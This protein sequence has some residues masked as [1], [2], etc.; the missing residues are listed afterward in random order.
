[1]THESGERGEKRDW[2]RILVPLAAYAGLAVLVWKLGLFKP[3]NI[4]KHSHGSILGISWLAIAVVATYAFLGMLALPV[5]PLA[6]GAGALFGFVRGAIYV[7]VGSM[8]GAVG[9]FFLARTILQSA[10]RRLLG[11]YRHKF[12]GLKKGN[13]S[14][15]SFRIRVVPFLPFG[16]VNYAAAIAKV[17]A[18][19]FLAG[20]ALGILPGTLLAA[21]IGDRFYAGVTGGSRK[22]L[23]L[24]I[25]LGLLLLLLSFVPALLKK[26]NNKI[27]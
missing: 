6:Y 25:A 5:A 27:H 22:P 9:G 10:A 3:E 20:T 19:P 18:A 4:E 14:L 11:R 12:D 21:F 16:V 7:F 1:M 8:I 15:N 26:M 23:Y 13:V 17:P 24:A 2:V